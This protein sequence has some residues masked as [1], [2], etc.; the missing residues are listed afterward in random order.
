MMREVVLKLRM[1]TRKL[2]ANTDRSMVDR[3]DGMTRN[4]GGVCAN[5]TANNQQLVPPRLDSFLK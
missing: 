3:D 5:G 1:L 4:S 2:S